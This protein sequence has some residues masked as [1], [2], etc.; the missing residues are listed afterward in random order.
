M[1]KRVGELADTESCA[2]AR[3][4]RARHLGAVFGKRHDDRGGDNRQIADDHGAVVQR[5]R[6]REDRLEEFR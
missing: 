4:D 1:I 3:T 2:M 6:R 5:S